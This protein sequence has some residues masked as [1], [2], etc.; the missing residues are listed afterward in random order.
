MRK[1]LLSVLLMCLLLPV[2]AQRNEWLDPQ[3]NHVNR[4]PMRTHYFAFESREAAMVGNR[5]TSSNFLSLNGLWRFNWVRNSD[6]RPLDFY[7][8]N[9]NDKGWGYMPIPGMWEMNGFGHPVYVNVGWAWRNQFS[10]NPPHVP[11]ENNHVGSYRREIEIPANW[12]GKDIIIHFGSVTSNIYLWVNGRYVG[13]SE[14]SK[15]EAEFDITSFVRPGK[16]LIAF[17]VFRWCDGSYLEDQDFWRMT[18]VARNCFIYARERVRIEDLRVT[19]DLDENYINGSLN[20]EIT[21]KGNAAVSLELL[22]PSGKQVFRQDLRGRNRLQTTINL[23]NPLKWT[24]ETPYLYQLIATTTHR[25]ATEVIPIKVGFREVEIR[26]AQLLVNG[27][28]ILFKGVNRHDMNPDRGYYVTR[29][30]MR[31]DI[32]RM[33]ELNFNAVRTAHYPNDNYFYEL[34][35]KYGLYVIAE[36]NVE[37]H[38][39]GYGER[40]L[41]K[42]P[43][44]ALAHLERN[45]RNVQRS[46]NHPSVI[47]W[48]LGN[49]A[50]MGQNFLDA[51]H[52]IKKEDPSRPVQYE[53]AHGGE[54]TDIFAPMYLDYAGAER[55]SRDPNSKKPLIQCEYAHAMGNSMGGFKEYWDLKRKYPIYQ[56]GFIW[57]FADQALRR[58]NEDGIEIFVY[59]GDFNK[60]DASDNNF[61]NNG[62]VSP[63]RNLNPHAHEVKYF[64]QNI[65]V[66]PVD[67]K[68]GLVEIY[69]EHFFI[70]LS[71]YYAVW[72]VL[73]NGTPTQTGII[74]DIKAKPQERV[75]VKI[76][77]NSS[78]FDPSKEI[79]I[80]FSFK[81][82]EAEPML[83]AGF[84]VAHEQLVYQP[85]QF[86][87]LKHAVHTAKNQEMVVP[88]IR[89]KDWNFLQILGD[90]FKIEFNKHSGNL[91]SFNYKG[92]NLLKDDGKLTPNFWRAPTDNDMGAR[93]QI[94]Y[95]AWNNPQMR[96][97]SLRHRIEDNI[98]IVTS[99]YNMRSVYAKLKMEYRIDHAGG[100]ILTQSMQVSDTA[101]VS[102]MFRY[103]F[104]LQ[105]PKS[106][107]RISYY[108]RGPFENYSDR[109]HASKIGKFN[110][111]VDEQFF[112]YIRPQETG[113]KT[114]IRYW[115]VLNNAGQGLKFESTVPFSA[116]TLHY[117]IESLD[118]GK[119]K[120]QR[121]SNAIP[122]VDYTNVCIDLHH[123]GLACVNSWGAIPLERYRVKYANYEFKVKLTPLN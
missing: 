15:L 25:N 13:Y 58:I 51:Y 65:W 1:L 111:T 93:L 36:A 2:V 70:D 35:D 41:A 68:Q 77:Y 54:G 119:E 26:N 9:F 45:Q 12:S 90:R 59:G 32:R 71:N 14:D 102:E 39:M 5:E 4:L 42:E 112:P 38:G 55:Y 19:P 116:S 101:R 104:Q 21:L 43:T 16:N 113:N 49:E 85:W 46:F 40:T 94:R 11:V 10:P 17:Q 96:L 27:Q 18:G 75:R 48:S 34:T 121:H 114:D 73:E 76:P 64:Q 72:K 29:E 86:T 87:E 107:D 28:P 83:P 20:V 30:D 74:W 118:D 53:Q 115:K 31:R 60:Y 122:Q 47:I 82:K 88:E 98:V 7:Q 103:G 52:W 24:A 57:D 56:G 44:Y 37:S 97:D 89:T 100:I 92:V 8:V 78:Q 69:N 6:A 91:V 62:V 120:D 109:N 22:D 33:K 95:S 63:D 81:L 61:N 105:M 79:L 84:Q 3:V 80:N 106:F 50:G 108:G 99:Y 110:Q 123:T 117:S 67:L 66:T 23:N